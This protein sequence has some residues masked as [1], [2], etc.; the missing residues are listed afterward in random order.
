[1][2]EIFKINKEIYKNNCPQGNLG[3]M[4]WS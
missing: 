1:M 3:N 4:F 2:L